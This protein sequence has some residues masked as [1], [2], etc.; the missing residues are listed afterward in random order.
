MEPTNPRN[1][2]DEV[3]EATFSAP[4]DQI[5]VRSGPES[6]DGR[7]SIVGHAAVFDRLSHDLGGFRE[8]VA[9]GAFK[10]VLNEAPD[11]HFDW[12]HDTR[13]VLARTRNNSLELSEDPRGLRIYAKVA[14][15]SYAADLGILLEEGMIDQMSF[16]FT[17]DEEEWNEDGEGRITSKI[18]RVGNLYDVTVTAQGAYP[19]TD[20]SM[21]RSRYENAVRSG[22]APL[23]ER[24]VP[25]VA[26][27]TN[28]SGETA[29]PIAALAPGG[30]E[31]E[32]AQRRRRLA[33]ARAKS[34]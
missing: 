1:S 20:A 18:L 32:A 31:F 23:T 9:R 22:R 7:Y 12:D 24:A 13:Y 6:G 33:L 3:F 14:P 27:L 26:D 16:K 4:I 10:E 25:I 5:N 8:E 17:I 34:A 2:V 21:V 30:S 19:Q 15:T 11:V 28:G 29:D